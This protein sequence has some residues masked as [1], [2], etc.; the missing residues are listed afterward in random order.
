MQSRFPGWLLVPEAAAGPHLVVLAITVGGR[1]QKQTARRRWPGQ[2]PA[3][4]VKLG[5][6]SELPPH[7]P[8]AQSEAPPPSASLGC[9]TSTVLLFIQEHCPTSL[10]STRR[11]GFH[12]GLLRG[13]TVMDM[14]GHGCS[15]A[16]WGAR[17]HRQRLSHE[18]PSVLTSLVLAAWAHHV[19][20]TRPQ[21][22]EAC[23]PRWLSR[24]VME[25]KTPRGFNHF[26]LTESPTGGGSS[27]CVI[28]SYVTF[29][30][31][32]QSAL[33]IVTPQVQPPFYRLIQTTVPGPSST[34]SAWVRACLHCKY[35][36]ALL[37]AK[38][39]TT[40]LWLPTV[41]SHGASS[42]RRPRTCDS[43]APSPTR[44]PGG[45]GLARRSVRTLHE[46][47]GSRLPFPLRGQL[48]CSCTASPRS[49]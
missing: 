41:I 36:H 4:Q 21:T 27:R 35:P 20:V 25:N 1:A 17:G 24:A 9:G 42:G 31:R 10:P 26:L 15:R 11:A 3:H 47:R 39:Q 43:M 13:R 29:W 40:A 7:V 16:A 2:R 22:G 44:A 33:E 46:A 48:G 14:S 37:G 38:G 8:T 30:T 34:F 32:G 12:G 18:T 28:S 49:W 45:G 6:Q 23:H 19:S 5:C